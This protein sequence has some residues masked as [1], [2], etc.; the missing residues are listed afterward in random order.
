MAHAPFRAEPDRVRVAHLRLRADS[1]GVDVRVDGEALPGAVQLA[2]K[3]AKGL[4]RLPRS[5]DDEEA[6]A[7]RVRIACHVAVAHER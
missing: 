7:R 5:L 1:W 3:V 2:G 4:L 6:L